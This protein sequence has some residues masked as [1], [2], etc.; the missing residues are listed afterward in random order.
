MM[1]PDSP[2]V[3][4]IIQQQLSGHSRILVAPLNW[5][6][7][8]AVRCIPL[9]EACLKAGKTVFIASD[10]QALTFLQKEFP[11]LPSFQLPSYSITYP[12]P[13]I[14]G[15][16]IYQS[17]GILKA[18]INEH[19][20][21]KKIVAFTGCTA[22]IS[23]NRWGV[24]HKSTL[25]I[26]ITHQMN[27]THRYVWLAKAGTY[28]HCK[29]MRRFDK[30]WIPD[31]KGEKALAPTLSFTDSDKATYLGPLTT[32]KWQKSEK[33]NDMAVIL[34]GPE[35]RRA[36][37]END[38]LNI[39]SDFTS[40][41]IV[42]VR[43]S[44]KDSSNATVPEHIQMIHTASRDQIEHILNT[45]RIL[46]ARS[47]YTTVMDTWHSDIHRIWIPTEGQ[48]E[49]EYLAKRLAQL[50]ENVVI[51]PNKI[52]KLKNIITSLTK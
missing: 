11:S 24:Y 10:G 36:I 2:D 7:G 39:L 5:G 16:L 33:N 30:I 20:D 41:K 18:V 3:Q 52:N 43:G 6:L 34:S 45:T 17:P 38:L 32:V 42:F 28:I 4:L 29:L 9:I 19:K 25:N 14:V 15:N 35:P 37:L 13:S 23:D 22:I 46:V 31:Y 1:I 26:Y 40:L 8:H 47:G 12:F 51:L 21:V 49:Q 44:D 50:P 27:L 48:S